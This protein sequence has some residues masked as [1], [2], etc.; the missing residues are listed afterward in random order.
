MEAKSIMFILL[1]FT[2]GFDVDLN[3]VIIAFI[4]KIL[5]CILSHRCVLHASRVSNSLMHYC[6]RKS[7]QKLQRPT[8]FHVN[9]AGYWY[10]V[11]N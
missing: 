9:R 8:I 11:F 4:K 2:L 6:S 5:Y 7:G 1:Y 3:G 10:K